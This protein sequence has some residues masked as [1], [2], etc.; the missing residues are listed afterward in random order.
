MSAPCQGRA[1]EVVSRTCAAER[2]SL[3]KRYYG[4]SSGGV[5]P[6]GASGTRAMTGAAGLGEGGRGVAAGR[7]DALDA[8]PLRRSF[9]WGCDQLNCTEFS[10]LSGLQAFHWDPQN[11][12][13]P[14]GR[15]GTRCMRASLCLK[16][17]LR[18]YLHEHR[19]PFAVFLEGTRIGP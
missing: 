5:G 2:W 1:L 6:R 3:E 7:F 4:R 17:H 13:V 19:I 8:R 11:S 16:M 18:N 12:H 15:L 14:L 9:A 10:A